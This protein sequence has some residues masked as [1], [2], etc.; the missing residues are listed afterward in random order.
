M[1]YRLTDGQD[2]A[3]ANRFLFSDRTD[4]SGYVELIDFLGGKEEGPGPTCSPSTCVRGSSG[5]TRQA[6][7]CELPGVRVRG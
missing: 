3:W 5:A 6:L 2:S 7:A 4:D 1:E